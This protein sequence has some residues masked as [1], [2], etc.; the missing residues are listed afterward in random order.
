MIA[1]KINP[2]TIDAYIHATPSVLQQ[3]ISQLHECIRS[4]APGAEE[5]LEWR[6]PSYSYKNT[7]VAFGVFK[8][9][10][11]LYPMQSALKAFSKELSKYKTGDEAIQF[12]LDKRLPLTLIRKIVKFRVKESMEETAAY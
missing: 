6:M 5:S 8:N 12:R 4:A 2:T 3:R 11:G 7:L 1:Q 10:I 9:Y